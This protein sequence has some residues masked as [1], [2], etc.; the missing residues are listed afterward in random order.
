MITLFNL[1]KRF[2]PLLLLFLLIS[3][4]LFRANLFA[5]ES[6][7][8]KRL[9]SKQVSAIQWLLQQVVPN[10]TVPLPAPYRRKLILSYRVPP[11]HPVY[12]YL[13]GRSYIYD[14]ALAVIAFTMTEH[15]Q[16]AESILLALNRL[17]TK[18][19]ALWFGYNTHNSWP[20]PKDHEGA[21]Q[22]TGATAWVGYSIVYYLQKRMEENENFL[23]DDPLAP[24]LLTF[25]E[26]IAKFLIPKQI[27][28]KSDLRYGLITGGIGTY[29]LKLSS[30]SKIITDEY[31]S[32]P[33]EWVSSE[34]NID[35]YFFLRDLARITK[36]AIYNKSSTLIRTGL[37][38]IWDPNSGQFFRGI[39][40]SQGIDRYLPLDTASWGAFFLKAIAEPHKANLSLAA[41]DHFYAT[42]GNTLKG[43]APYY[44][45]TVYEDARVN[46]HYYPE[47]P[48]M[49]WNKLRFIW[50][51]GSF[52]VAAAFAKL[53]DR[54]RAF[55]IIEDIKDLEVAGGI[56][57]A[58]QE[59][60]YRFSTF[61]SVASTAWLVISL[62]LLINPND[63]F[64]GN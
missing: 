54:P 42:S 20:S 52:G 2:I 29:N 45:E 53:G 21:L 7:N 5:E 9:V 51:E 19:G 40:K 48:G 26:T 37:I 14:D 58:S 8:F 39:K 32:N 57:Y 28:A 27:L 24:K 34:H 18:E 12:P 46:S 64:W 31:D 56:R 41:T 13:S 43:Y 44:K 63:L 59:I 3:S 61:P 16:Q 60:P 49:T 55:T 62:Q 36:K 50:G 33:V 38:K 4:G 10:E 47:T 22:R 23:L 35:A 15:Y 17:S 1:L 11:G 30:D 6:I 25:A